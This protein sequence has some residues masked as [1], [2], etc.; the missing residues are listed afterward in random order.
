MKGDLYIWS[1][2][3]LECLVNIII[4]IV[5]KLHKTRNLNKPIKELTITPENKFITENL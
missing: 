4:T 2:E 5:S 3:S 1:T